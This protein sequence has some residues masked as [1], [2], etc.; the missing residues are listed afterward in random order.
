MKSDWWNDTYL[1]LAFVHDIVSRVSLILTTVY[2][3]LDFSAL[4]IS[5]TLLW[6]PFLK[7]TFTFTGWILKCSENNTG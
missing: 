6:L 2:F 3:T 1:S 7:N 5:L 4:Q